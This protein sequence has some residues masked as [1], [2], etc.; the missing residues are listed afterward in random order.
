MV[1]FETT[2]GN[3]VVEV[4]GARAPLSAANFLKYVR[5]G[6]YD[7]TIFHRVIANF[8][9]QGGGY[10][11]DGKEKPTRASVPNESGNGLSNRR[12]TVAMARFNDPHSATAQ[13]YINV[14]DNYSLDPSTVRWGYAVFGK[15]VDG[16]DVIDRI[17]HTATGARGS[18]QDETPLEPIVITKAE[19]VPLAP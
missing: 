19:V 7:G 8:V 10:T 17:A 12:G 14:G 9:V 2:A 18:F 11:A 13:F 15:V 3:F 1:R 6:H 16:M 5:D 4:D